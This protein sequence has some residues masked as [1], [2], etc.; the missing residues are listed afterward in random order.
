MEQITNRRAPATR[1]S[2]AALALAAPAPPRTRP[3]E[4]PVHFTKKSPPQ[5]VVSTGR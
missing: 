5:R 2:M 4:H 3:G 1:F